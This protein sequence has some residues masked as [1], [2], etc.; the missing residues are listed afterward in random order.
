MSYARIAAQSS[1]YHK[2]SACQGRICRPV[3]PPDL[4]QGPTP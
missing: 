2:S 3:K 4:P 1:F